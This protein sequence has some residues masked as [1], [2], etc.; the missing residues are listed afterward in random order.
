MQ[1]DYE[2]IKA[3]RTFEI[4]ADLL[5]KKIFSG[6]YK[7]GD[8]LPSERDLC[9]LLAVSRSAVREAYHALELSGIVEIRKGNEGGAFIRYPTHKP[10]TQSIRD[11][12]L[13]RK[14]SLSDMAE[15]RS[16]L[17]KD[18]AELAIERLQESDLLLL[19]EKVDQAFEKTARKLP[20]SEE[21]VQFHV[22]FSEIS[23]NPLL[24]MV[25]SSVMDLFILIL[26]SVSPDYRVSHL[27]AEE[28]L[29]IISL[30][31]AGQLKPLLDYMDQHIRE[32]NSR[33]LEYARKNP[34]SNSVL[35]R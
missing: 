5:K 1:S 25:Y 3:K 11:F 29:R 4:V 7:V 20:A 12:I 28:H 18:L 32:S 21:N 9:D 27:V 2:P 8:R 30:L 24:I 16:I 33:L 10:I 14:M 35:L 34:V 23:R 17:E 13:L 19:R 22:R 6:E 15:A 31:Q 26:K